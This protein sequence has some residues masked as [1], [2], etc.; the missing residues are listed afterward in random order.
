MNT[1]SSTD[2]LNS[3]WLVFG[4]ILLFPSFVSVKEG[5]DGWSRKGK[6]SEKSTC[7]QIYCM[8][9]IV[10]EAALMDVLSRE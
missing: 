6:S 5:L 9:V 2:N 10:S 7:V 8:L 4:G 3:C 1:T